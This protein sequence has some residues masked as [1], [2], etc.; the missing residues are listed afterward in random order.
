MT[1]DH[2]LFFFLVVCLFQQAK[3]Q[4]IQPFRSSQM[5]TRSKYWSVGWIRSD[6]VDHPARRCDN[7]FCVCDGFDGLAIHSFCDCGTFVFLSVR[8]SYGFS[9]DFRENVKINLFKMWDLK[10]CTVCLSTEVYL[11]SMDGSTLRIDFN[12][13]SG[14]DVCRTINGLHLFSSQISC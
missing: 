3:V 4:A 12:L 10:A 14:L 11:H 2:R 7:V 5:I 6:R 13:V 9:V 1:F 8:N